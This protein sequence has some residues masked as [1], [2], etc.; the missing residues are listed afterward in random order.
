MMDVDNCHRAAICDGRC[1]RVVVVVVAGC[2][3][4]CRSVDWEDEVQGL[5]GC[6]F[7]RVSEGDAWFDGGGVCWA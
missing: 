4:L 5:L 7:A 6:E 2:V 1:I 3:Y